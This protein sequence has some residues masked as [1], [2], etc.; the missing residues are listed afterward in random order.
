MIGGSGEIRTH[1]QFLVDSFQD[2]CNKPDSATLPNLVE[3]PGIE[4]GVPEG[5]GFTVHCITID[6]SSPLNGAPGETRT[7]T[8]F[9]NG[10]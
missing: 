2:C 3:I 10:F 6:A 7:P 8:P 5:G 9:D 4:P 1:G